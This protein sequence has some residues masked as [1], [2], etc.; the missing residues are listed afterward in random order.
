MLTFCLFFDVFWAFLG[1]FDVFLAK[2][3]TDFPYFIYTY[4]KVSIVS[5]PTSVA[6]PHDGNSLVGF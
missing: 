3:L 1:F 2:V 5:I 4:G 6:L